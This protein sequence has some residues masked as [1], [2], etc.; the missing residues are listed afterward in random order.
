MWELQSTAGM[1][2]GNGGMDMKL[3]LQ[4]YIV[5]AIGLI[6]LLFWGC[7]EEIPVEDRSK[8][9]CRYGD[10]VFQYDSEMDGVYFGGVAD[11]KKINDDVFFIPEKI[12]GLD[13]VGISDVG[14][15]YL[16]SKTIVVPKSVVKNISIFFQTHYKNLE[17]L[18]ILS[19]KLD[20]L[21]KYY[22]HIQ[23][24]INTIIL[25][26]K[27]PPTINSFSNNGLRFYVPD[28]SLYLYQ[29]TYPRSYALN[30]LPISEYGDDLSKFNIDKP[31]WN[32]EIETHSSSWYYYDVYKNSEVILTNG[33]FH[34][35]PYSVS[36]SDKN[37]YLNFIYKPNTII[38][39]LE[40]YSEDDKPMIFPEL[41]DYYSRIYVYS[42][43]PVKIM[44][45]DG[46]YPG[47]EMTKIN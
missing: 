21:K 5:L 36:L 38:C 39:D 11:G 10:L 23:D 9:E 43:T 25:F 47:Y 2:G 4:K 18:V 41:G 7:S 44:Y 46:D 37:V 27:I 32:Y 19:D 8:G 42:E 22:S 12:Y 45:S 31:N 14:K 17:T 6:Y 15:G 20:T 26:S 30:F 34:S 13:V 24:N 1:I 28:D 3:M 40:I 16:N 35:E 29:T 33:V